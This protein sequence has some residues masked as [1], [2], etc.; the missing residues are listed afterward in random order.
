MYLGGGGEARG[1]THTLATVA[2]YL[3]TSMSSRTPPRRGTPN[4]RI[5]AVCLST[6]LDITIEHTVLYIA[7]QVCVVV[8]KRTC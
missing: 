2:V 7:T 6:V 4:T 1:D 8:G 5:V 3:L